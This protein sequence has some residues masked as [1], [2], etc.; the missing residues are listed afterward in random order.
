M[1]GLYVQFAQLA[2]CT[3]DMFRGSGG[4]SAEG[5]ATVVKDDLDMYR[6]I[7]IGAGIKPE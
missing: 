3:Y 1:Y 6:K 4:I 7:A 2:R 5:F